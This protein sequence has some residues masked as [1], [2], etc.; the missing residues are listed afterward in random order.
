M[1]LGTI[2][3]LLEA[4]GAFKRVGDVLQL[5]GL[6]T[7]PTIAMPA[8]F[9]VPESESAQPNDLGSNIFEQLITSQFGV[10]I[11]VSA[12]GA[13]RGVARESL[14]DLEAEVLTALAGTKVEG[15]DRPLVYAGAR[16]ISIGAGR[17]SRLLS[18][19]AVW[20]FR[21]IRNPS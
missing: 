6:D 1:K 19:R 18:F 11:V 15:L 2:I 10:A 16:L 21:V 4:G 7:E 8:A 17:V 9:V 5:A 12:D 20:R 3:Q 13:K 14:E